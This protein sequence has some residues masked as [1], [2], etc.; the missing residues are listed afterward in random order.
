M[1]LSA[2]GHEV[3]LETC[4]GFCFEFLALGV[5]RPEQYDEV[6]KASQASKDGANRPAGTFWNKN[7]CVG[8][9]MAI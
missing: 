3:V 7:S 1:N 6:K 2:L 8:R 4:C 9:S 5:V